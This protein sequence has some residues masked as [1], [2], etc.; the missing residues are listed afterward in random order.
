MA[1]RADEESRGAYKSSQKNLVIRLPFKE[2]GIDKEGV[3]EL[4][5][6]SSLGLPKYYEWRSRSG[7]TFCFYQKKIEWVMLLERHE[8]AFYEAMEY[9]NMAISRG[10]PF[11]WSQGEFLYEIANPKRIN[12]IKCEHEKRLNKKKI[13]YKNPLKINIKYVDLDTVYGQEKTCI[14]CHT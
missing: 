13:L 5:E 2:D 3:Y 7:C 14:L 9:E 8:E 6:F 4:L 10:S 12:E 1:I 11:T